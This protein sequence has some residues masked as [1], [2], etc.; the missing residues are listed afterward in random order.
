MV[1]A[2]MDQLA[3]QI[4]RGE[5][6][7]DPEAVA[8]AMLRRGFA[9]GSLVLVP[10]EPPDGAAVGAREDEPAPGGDAA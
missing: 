9:P 10:A 8:E 2:G 1:N 4:A 7:V 5:Y 6:V 3:E